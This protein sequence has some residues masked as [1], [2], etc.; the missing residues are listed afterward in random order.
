M[1]GHQF[2]KLVN[3][4]AKNFRSTLVAGDNSAV[5]IVNQDAL[6]QYIDDRP[7]AFLALA[8]RQ[9]SFFGSRDVAGHAFNGRRCPV[10]IKDWRNVLLCPD[11]P[12]VLMYPAYN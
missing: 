10:L 8:Q 9:F 1:T 4:H 6:S 7:I 12:T 11:D 5:G 3:R 2:K